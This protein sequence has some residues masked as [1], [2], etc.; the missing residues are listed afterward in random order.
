[1]YVDEDEKAFTCPIKVSALFDVHRPV[2]HTELVSLNSTQRNWVSFARCKKCK[3]SIVSTGC[4]RHREN[5]EFGSYFFPDR[6]NRKFCFET[7]KNFETQGK[8]FSVTQGKI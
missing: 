8:Y 7:G 4:P 3:F 1:M 2:N 5:R 6:E